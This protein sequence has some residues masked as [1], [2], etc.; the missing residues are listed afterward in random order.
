MTLRK[1]YAKDEM[2]NV[3][4]NHYKNYNESKITIDVVSNLM[5]GTNKVKWI[6]NL[7]PKWNNF[8]NFY[9]K[10]HVASSIINWFMCDMLALEF[11]RCD[12]KFEGNRTYRNWIVECE[13]L[14]FILSSKTEVVLAQN[15]EQS[16]NLGNALV[17]LHYNLF[18]MA[19]KYIKNHRQAEIDDGFEVIEAHLKKLE[20]SNI[21]KDDAFVLY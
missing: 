8:L 19:L 14:N 11:G 18:N 7:D 1:L 6:K 5:N 4:K 13:G 9:E 10:D 15:K 16:K 3:I 12:F 20:E 2:F 21:I 17:C